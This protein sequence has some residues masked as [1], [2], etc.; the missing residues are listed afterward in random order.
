MSV[1][2]SIKNLLN[3]VSPKKVTKAKSST[4]ERS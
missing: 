2:M 4:K 3:N 1:Y